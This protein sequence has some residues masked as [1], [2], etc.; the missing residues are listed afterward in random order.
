[1]R[2]LA[3]ISGVLLLGIV[4]VGGCESWQPTAVPMPAIERTPTAATTP[5]PS[6]A[7]P[8]GRI[9]YERDIWGNLA[10]YVMDSNG[11]NRS[12]VSMTTANDRMAAWSPDG[13]RI[14]FAS[15]RD[16]QFEI[17]VMN[18]DGSNQSRL[19]DN[20]TDDWYPAW[21]PDG[22]KIAFESS[23]DGNAEIYAMRRDGSDQT[24]LT[25]SQGRDQRPAWSP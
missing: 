11:L 4:L 5:T 3:A 15:D 14:A 2:R 23:R 6:V 10:I 8:P 16:G 18:A 1:M 22:D 7:L 19:T 9:A 20:L 13:R 24:R 25:Y 17:Y 21:S 12:R